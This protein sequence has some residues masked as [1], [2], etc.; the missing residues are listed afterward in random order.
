MKRQLFLHGAAGAIGLA[1]VASLAH[2]APSD[3][4]FTTEQVAFFEQKVV[5]ILKANCFKCHGGDKVKA[6]L[7]LS[8]REGLVKGGDSG[9]AVDLQNPGASRLL[10]AINYQDGLEMPPTGKLQPKDIDTLTRWVKLRI[11]WGTD[12][13]TK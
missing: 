3:R 5:P 9:P 7:R 10:Q 8:S 1:C 12:E 4:P 6:G 11:P 2:A 13:G